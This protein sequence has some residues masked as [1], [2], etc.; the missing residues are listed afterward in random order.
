MRRNSNYDSKNDTHLLPSKQNNLMEGSLILHPGQTNFLICQS[1]F[2]CASYLYG[3]CKVPERCPTCGNS[4]NNNIESIP[5]S[6]EEAFEFE[7]NPLHGLSL[8]FFPRHRS[9]SS[10]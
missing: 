3:S 9:C 2:W 4:N 8:N 6:M 1:C 7:Y 10:N 5:I